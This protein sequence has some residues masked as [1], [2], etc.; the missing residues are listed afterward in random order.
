MML[1]QSDM[2]ALDVMIV[3]LPLDYGLQVVYYGECWRNYS[4][5]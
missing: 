4:Y 5:H 1:T 2:H 3:V